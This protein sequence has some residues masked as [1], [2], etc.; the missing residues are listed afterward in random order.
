M[1]SYNFQTC[2][3]CEET[4]FSSPENV[5]LHVESGGCAALR[6]RE[7]AQQNLYNS[8]RVNQAG[9]LSEETLQYHGGGSPN[10]MRA[11]YQCP[12]CDITF[13][14]LGSLCQHLEDR[15]ARILKPGVVFRIL[16][17]MAAWISSDCESYE[18][19]SE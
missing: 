15:H 11:P 17:K 8:V 19:D 6:G 18:T 7:N 4:R 5:V 9:L 16:R 3:L 12:E 14:L 10:N 2:P 13:Q 1:Y